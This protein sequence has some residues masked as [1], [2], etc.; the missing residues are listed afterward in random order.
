MFYHEI[1][2]NCIPF[3]ITPPWI[4]TRLKFIVNFHLHCI[5]AKSFDGNRNLMN[6]QIETQFSHFSFPFVSQQIY[7][8]HHGG[9]WTLIMCNLDQLQHGLH[10]SPSRIDGI[11][12]SQSFDESNGDVS[13][14]AHG[15]VGRQHHGMLACMLIAS[16][17][18]TLICN[19]HVQ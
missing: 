13:S 2:Q 5:I 15:I 4:C 18:L 19:W 11:C 12:L 17:P 9:N 1:L 3:C 6:I 16:V 7:W 14:F 10:C 8:A